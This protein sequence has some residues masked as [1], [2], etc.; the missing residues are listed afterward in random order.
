MTS[1]L[2]L[3]KLVAAISI[4]IVV[5]MANYVPHVAISFAVVK[6]SIK[7]RA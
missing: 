3:R 2:H 5:Q 6:V 7:D 4:E 1:T